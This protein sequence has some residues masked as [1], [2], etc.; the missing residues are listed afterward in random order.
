VAEHVF[1]TA[2]DDVTA[3]DDAL[4]DRLGWTRRASGSLP[5]PGA[6]A[7]PG[8]LVQIRRPGRKRP[9]LERVPGRSSAQVA[10]E[11]GPLQLTTAHGSIA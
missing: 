5:G 8:E 9:R 7:R 11:E 1:E 6:P 10:A 3:A 2:G 4:A